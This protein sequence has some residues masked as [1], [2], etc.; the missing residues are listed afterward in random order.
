MTFTELLKNLVLLTES[1][2]VPVSGI[3]KHEARLVE[4]RDF[5]S[6][7]ELSTLVPADNC[8]V[9]KGSVG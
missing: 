1:V 2:A 7:L 3:I 4:D 5:V 6:I 9:D 8:L